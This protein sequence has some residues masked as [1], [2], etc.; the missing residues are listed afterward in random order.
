MAS[1][2]AWIAPSCVHGLPRW[3]YVHGAYLR[4][5]GTPSERDGSAIRRDRDCAC[6]VLRSGTGWD[7]DRLLRPCRSTMEYVDSASALWRGALIVDT[8]MLR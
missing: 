3:E 1:L 6:G 8:P 5:V 4:G 7:E 2:D